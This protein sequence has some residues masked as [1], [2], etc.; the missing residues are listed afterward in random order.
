[1]AGITITQSSAEEPS[2][3]IQYAGELGGALGAGVYCPAVV[4]SAGILKRL[5]TLATTD[6][7]VGVVD[8][9]GNVKLDLSRSARP[10]VLSPADFGAPWDGLHDDLPAILA[11]QAAASTVGTVV[12]VRT[13]LPRGAGYCA[14]NLDITRPLK[15]AGATG[16]AYAASGLTFAPGKGVIIHSVA[17]APD[18]A[19]GAGTHLDG[20][21]IYSTMLI[22]DALGYGP[23]AGAGWS[24]ALA[25]HGRNGLQQYYKGNCVVDYP[26]G[27]NPTHFFRAG[28]DGI[29]A[30]GSPAWGSAICGQTFVDGGVTWTCEAFLIPWVAA[31][32]KVVGDRV[33]GPTNDNRYYLEV[34]STTGDA[35]TG[36]LYPASGN[37]AL[38]A[39]IV[40]NHVTWRVS[41]HRGIDMRASASV[42]HC[43]FSGFTNAAMAVDSGDGTSNANHWDCYRNFAQY[44]GM[45]LQTSGVNTN[46]GCA[47][48]FRS[49]L[50]GQQMPGTGG[51]NVWDTAAANS[52]VACYAES[53]TGSGHLSTS[54]GGSFFFGCNSEN[55]TPELVVAPS[56]W[57]GNV[58]Q[59]GFDAASTGNIFVGN[60]GGGGRMTTVDLH[61]AKTITSYMG[62]QDGVV[63]FGVN[64]TGETGV[65]GITISDQLPG[66]PVG[67]WVWDYSGNQQAAS[68]AFPGPLAK[69]PSGVNWNTMGNTTGY[70]AVLLGPAYFAV[71]GFGA[72]PPSVDFGTAA[73]VAGRWIIG[74][75]RYNSA[76]AV[77]ATNGWRCTVS[78][79]PGTWVALAN[80]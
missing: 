73:P 32:A 19:S 79:T 15:G 18:G 67:F 69:A 24:F 44:V 5:T 6:V 57:Y 25:T 55:V 61:G 37:Y 13:E 75:I 33:F 38:N 7:I 28:G 21:Q 1:M 31:T 60:G 26:A 77:G 2:L 22:N 48:G 41:Y 11:M 3:T 29:T 54:V 63:A 42:E 9:Y 17:T 43:F 36:A 65:S 34:V 68:I 35:K 27:L 4:D 78:G 62:R 51:H 59:S 30:V 80:L 20:I 45:G 56:S 16:G 76:V 52:F 64:A 40:D 10:P 74:S 58:P 66:W 8:T 39:T 23:Q 46:G 49:N 12:G 71:S 72:D 53:G 47:I 70:G 50:A 14:G